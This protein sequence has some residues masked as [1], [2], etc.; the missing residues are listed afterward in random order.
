VLILLYVGSIKV[1][2]EVSDLAEHRELGPTLVIRVL[3]VIDS[4]VVDPLYT[5]DRIPPI[6]VPGTLLLRNAYER[7][8]AVHIPL[9]RQPMADDLL[10]L[11]KASWAGA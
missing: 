3:E 2:F 9:K 4:I 6:P 5:G 11:M 7:S 10:E 1:Q 8:T